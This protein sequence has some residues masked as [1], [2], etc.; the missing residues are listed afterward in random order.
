[1][2]ESVRALEYKEKSNALFIQWKQRKGIIPIFHKKQETS[3]WIDHTAG[4]FIRDGVVCPEKWF[5]QSVRPL[6]LLKEAYGVGEW[7]L[8]TDHLCQSYSIGK[9]Q[10]WRRVSE[11]TYG[12]L[13][14]SEDKIAPYHS[15]YPIEHYNNTYLQQCAVVNVKKSGGKSASDMDEIRAYAV[16]D[17]EY[18]YHQLEICDPTVI[19]C[20]YTS[21]V[22]DILTGI[23]MR[24]E[25]NENLFYHIALNG[26]TVLVLDYWHPANQYPDIM[27]YYGLMGIYQ[28]A[29]L[30]KNGQR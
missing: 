29:L 20:G 24:K 7:D 3:V 4:S 27:N 14:S 25:K 15:W 30:M 12:L 22:L 10:M 23:P 18:L 17:K 2:E 16:F 9:N 8:I 26:H 19:I 11:W 21:S 13:T 1:M 5:H 6:Y 28:Q